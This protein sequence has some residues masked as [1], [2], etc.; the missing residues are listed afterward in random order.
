MET[1]YGV[2]EILI[3]TSSKK[4]R[5]IRLFSEDFQCDEAISNKDGSLPSYSQFG[6]SEK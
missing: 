3:D 6:L 1:E 2:S 5:H 4:R